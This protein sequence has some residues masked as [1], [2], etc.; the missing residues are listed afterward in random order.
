ML[1]RIL[2]S[3]ATDGHFRADI[4]GQLV[5]LDRVLGFEPSGVAW[6]VMDRENMQNVTRNT[7]PT[8]LEAA[9]QVLAEVQ[10]RTNRAP[11]NGL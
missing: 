5:A 11:T 7:A 1:E 9:R 8:E 10:H 6:S 2:E 4:D 3:L